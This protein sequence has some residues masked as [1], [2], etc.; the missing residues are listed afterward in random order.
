MY[1][2]NLGDGPIP[3]NSLVSIKIRFLS[4]RIGGGG[5]RGG[6]GGDKFSYDEAQVRADPTNKKLL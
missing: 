1:W 5:V 6:E 4:S 2:L 3:L